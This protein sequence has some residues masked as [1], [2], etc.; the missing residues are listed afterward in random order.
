MPA[1][2]GAATTAARIGASPGANAT[3]RPS[4]RPPGI[5]AVPVL[6]IAP[7]RRVRV[8]WR[9]RTRRRR[10]CPAEQRPGRRREGHRGLR[11]GSEE[12]ADGPQQRAWRWS[13]G[14]P[15]RARPRPTACP[16]PPGRA[17]PGGARRSAWPEATGRR[18]PRRSRCTNRRAPRPASAAASGRDARRRSGARRRWRRGGTGVRCPRGSEPGLRGRRQREHLGHRPGQHRRVEHVGAGF[19]DGATRRH[20]RR[21]GPPLRAERRRR[22]AVTPTAATQPAAASTSHRPPARAPAQSLVL[23]PGLQR[24]GMVLSPSV[25]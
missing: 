9:S 6:A 15:G 25:L 21:P 10:A 12:A 13:A 5:G 23:Q 8:C 18:A 4:D 14:R 7:G 20:S 2:P 24:H 11:T 1:P 3:T 22:L 19:G 16:R 17:R